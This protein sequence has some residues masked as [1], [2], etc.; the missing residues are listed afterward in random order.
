M[1]KVPDRVRAGSAGFFE[2]RHGFY[3]VRHGSSTRTR[4]SALV[5]LAGDGDERYSV[6]DGAS[7][8]AE[9]ADLVPVFS[10]GKEGPLAV[11]TGR[12]FI[13]LRDG[14]RPEQR[15]AELATAGFEIER[16]LPYAPNAAWLR[17]TNG[18]VAEALSRIGRLEA[19]PDMAHVEPQMLLD[20]DFRRS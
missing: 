6:Y 2:R 20:R 11:P 17:P 13:R 5:E 18:G 1:P 8:A 14:V 7:V 9:G 4:E 12:V 19:L 16:T 15:R 3:A 10:A